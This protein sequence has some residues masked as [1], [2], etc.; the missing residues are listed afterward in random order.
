[1]T[2]ITTNENKPIKG[3]LW[4]KKVSFA[5]NYIVWHF[6]NE[7]SAERGAKV[8][9]KSGFEFVMKEGERYV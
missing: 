6:A 2:V 9:V 5:R 1:M 8:F 7:K 4:V 3:T